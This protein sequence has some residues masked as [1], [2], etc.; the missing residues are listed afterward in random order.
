MRLALLA[1]LLLPFAS[2]A[3]NWGLGFRL[4]DPSGLTVKKYNGDR[5]WEFNIGRT[6]L[7]NRNSYYHDRYDR[8]YADQHFNH[9]AHELIN[10]RYSRALGIQL[11]RL[12]HEDVKNATGLRWYYGFGGQ[13]RFQQYRYDY[14]YKVDNGPDWIVVSDQRDTEVDLGLDGVLGL[15]YKFKNAPVN[16]FT[17]GTLFMELLDAPF[18]FRGQ[19]GIGARY[20]FGGK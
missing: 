4:G 11:H 15:E 6:H 5:A 20:L 7:F 1:F 2:F 9:K 8:W 12:Y 13:L 17:D 14:R 16:I 3:Q 18:W 19:F 10:Y